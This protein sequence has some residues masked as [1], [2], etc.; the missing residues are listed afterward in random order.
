[1]ASSQP[2]TTMEVPGMRQRATSTLDVSTDNSDPRCS[3]EQIEETP[4]FQITLTPRIIFSI[5]CVLGFVCFALLTTLFDARYQFFAFHGNMEDAAASCRKTA[6]IFAALAFVA[7][8][9][10]ISNCLV[11]RQRALSLQ[12]KHVL[13]GA[14][15]R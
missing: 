13:P 4:P 10:S 11:A 7:F 9:P 15:R 3:S 14:Y 5:V 12:K 1:M 8:L 2:L 6:I